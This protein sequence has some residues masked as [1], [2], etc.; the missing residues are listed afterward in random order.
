MDQPTFLK[1]LENHSHDD[2]YHASNVVML[3]F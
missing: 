2:T 1:T 3:L